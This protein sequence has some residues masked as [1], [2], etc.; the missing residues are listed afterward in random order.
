MT[1][2]FG[3][4]GTVQTA[5]G[6]PSDAY[7]GPVVDMHTHVLFDGSG[8]GTEQ[9]PTWVGLSAEM[10]RAGVTRAGVIAIAPAGDLETTRAQNDALHALV[11]AHPDRLFAIGSVHPDDGELALREID[12]IAGLG[13]SALKLHPNTQGLDVSSPAVL[14]TVTRATER[15]LPVLF[16]GFNPFDADQT[17]KILMLAAQVPEARI[18]LAHMGGPRF[19]ETLVFGM[20]RRF[21][22]YARNVW[23]DLSVTATT[24]ADSPYE[25]HLVWVAR[26]IGI[27]RVLFGSDFPVTTP[28]E[29]LRSV[30]ALGFDPEEERRILHDNAVSLF[31]L[32]ARP[33]PGR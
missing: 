3:C 6:P 26:Q 17:G 18:V 30:R 16:D 20:V 1:T 4:G 32:A 9:P 29:S 31:G 28:A 27:D 14:A 5:A 24:F 11:Q 23:V 2:L 25:T 7:G 12:R 13:F 19:V 15:G 33:V 8:M 21:S 10:E 22:W